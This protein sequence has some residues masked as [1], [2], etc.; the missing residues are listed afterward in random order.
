MKKILI[1]AKGEK[2]Q[3]FLKRLVSTYVGGNHYDVIYYDDSI[4][5][6]ENALYFKFHKL[7]P[8]SPSRMAE[9]YT[10]EYIQ[11]NI[12]IDSQ[13][14]V[15]VIYPLIRRFDKKVPINIVDSWGLKLDDDLISLIDT[16]D[17]V[18]NRMVSLLPDVPVVAQH[19]GLGL[20]EIMEIQ[21]PVGSSY[22]YRHLINIEQKK[23]KI[24]AVYRNNFMM[25]AKPTFMIKPNDILLAV[26]EPKILKNVY[27]AIKA[28]IG[29]FPSPY[30]RNIYYILDGRK[31]TIANKEEE[32]KSV[33]NIHKRL[34]SKMLH[35]KLL[36][37]ESPEFIDYVKKLDSLDIEVSVNY[38]TYPTSDEFLEDIDDCH[39]GLIVVNNAFFR[40]KKNRKML[41]DSEKAVFKLGYNDTNHIENTGLI[42]GGAQNLEIL[43][44]PMFDLTSQLAVGLTL[45]N[46]TPDFS[47]NAEIIE[48]FENL[49]VIYERKINVVKKRANPVRELYKEENLLQILPFTKG[50]INE[51]IWDIFNVSRVEKQHRFLRKFHQL[52]LPVRVSDLESK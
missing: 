30:G 51:S 6:D 12:I 40:D 39:G 14:D 8:T 38:R 47:D 45:Y 1:I 9:I 21:V 16:K 35:I 20:G 10:K 3:H 33:V 15:K 34:N 37:P 13:S 28:Q 31:A 49:S 5:P 7:D 29:Q 25:L 17:L 50:V 18:A 43:A 2:A 19:I 48:Y 4:T 11:V 46:I 36:H 27:K 41:Y 24:A 42:I 32:I 23:W 22:A 52:F 26:G 44:A